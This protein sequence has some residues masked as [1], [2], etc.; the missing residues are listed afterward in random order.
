MSKLDKLNNNY[1]K[2]YKK[3]I[4][5]SIKKMNDLN[6]NDILTI[7]NSVCYQQMLFRNK[8]KEINNK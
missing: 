6:D 1:T 8:Q 3:H 7:F 4:I 5:E 2:K